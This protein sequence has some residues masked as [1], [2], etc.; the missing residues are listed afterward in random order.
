MSAIKI[1]I[2]ED[3]ILIAEH[4]KDYLVGFGFSQVFMAHTKK[5]AI[6]V[7]DHIS[8]DLILLDLHL[9]EPKDGLEIA[10][11]IDEKGEPPYI[12]ITANAD[13]LIIQEAIHTRA[14]SYITKPVKKAD[15]FASIQIALKSKDKPETDFLLIKDSNTNLK[16]DFDEILYIEGNSNYINIFTK[17]QKVVT[18]QSLE[19]AELELPGNQFMRIHRSYIV[20][21]RAVQRTNAKSVFI[22]EMEVPI[23]RAN[24]SK[25]SD[26]LR[27]KKKG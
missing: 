16:L 22:G 26:F 19:W 2:V 10:K 1:L 17:T 13:M 27:K 9:Q 4:I 23:S 18:R 6:Q 7:M 25:M 8:P 12:F 3:E 14:T 20:N 11:M 15:L 21:L 24:V 5:L